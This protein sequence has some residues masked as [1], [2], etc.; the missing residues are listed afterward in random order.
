[1]FFCNDS[2]LKEAIA[3]GRLDVRLNTNLTSIDDDFIYL[4]SGNEKEPV[5]IKNDLVFI[6]AGGE[7][8]THFLEKAGIIIT[9]KFGETVLK[10]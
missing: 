1:M 9:K 6:F 8:P 4:A 5:K 7:L 3:A 2:L 10:H